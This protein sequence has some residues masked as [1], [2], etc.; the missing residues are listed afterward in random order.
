[1]KVWYVLILAV[2]I[3]IVTLVRPDRSEN[4]SDAGAMAELQSYDSRSGKLSGQPKRPYIVIDCYCNRLYLR[5]ADTVLLEADCST[6]S[7]AQLTDSLTGRK[8]TFGTPRG[9]FVVHSKL[10]NPWWRKP[11]WAFIEEGEEIPQEDTKRLD[12]EMLGD[13]AI[14]F[15]DGFF[16]HGTLYERLL[17]I[18]VTHGCVRLGSEDLKKL[19]A[20]V[21]M[22]TRIY[23]Y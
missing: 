16:I 22:G 5:T 8:W 2:V 14:G 18:S 13:Y 4:E 1:M 17:G 6:G 12:S 21:D 9:V 3:A 20:Q 19:Y 23:V 7:G 11:D 15:G 10:T